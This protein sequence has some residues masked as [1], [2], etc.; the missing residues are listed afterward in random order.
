[1]PGIRPCSQTEVSH[2]PCKGSC[3]WRLCTSRI[4]LCTTRCRGRRYSRC[5]TA[6][7]PTFPTLAPSGSESSCTSKTPESSTP[8]SGKEICA[9]I[10][11]RANLTESET[12]RLAESWRGGTLP[13]SKHRGT[14]FSRVYR[15]FYCNIWCRRRGRSTTTLYGYISYTDVPREFRDYIGVLDFTANIPTNRENASGVSANL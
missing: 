2:R 14:C 13:S 3:S 5:F 10:A 6:R 15:S 1:M 9:A 7:K 11:R 4:R 8:W 12:R